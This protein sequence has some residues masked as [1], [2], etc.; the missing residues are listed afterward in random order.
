MTALSI[1]TGHA[2]TVLGSTARDLQTLIYAER[3]QDGSFIAQVF[4]GAWLVPLGYLVIKSGLFPKVL[5]VL[6]ATACVG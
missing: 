2:Y 1:A 5:S 3:L 4:F 6:L